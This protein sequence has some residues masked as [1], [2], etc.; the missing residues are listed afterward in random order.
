MKARL[1][2]SKFCLGWTFKCTADTSFSGVDQAIVTVKVGP[3]AKEFQVH[4][5]LLCNASPCF[6]GALEVKLEEGQN[7]SITMD[8]VSNLDLLW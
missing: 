2:V 5:D 7:F 1:Q 8:N 6:K 3:E 4:R